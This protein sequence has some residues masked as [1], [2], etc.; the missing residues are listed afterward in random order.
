MN[1]WI[2]DTHR[3]VTIYLLKLGYLRTIAFAF[4]FKTGPEECFWVCAVLSGIDF[5][6]ELS[7]PIKEK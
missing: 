5:Y 2:P 3:L 7:Q 4:A 1:M 6:L